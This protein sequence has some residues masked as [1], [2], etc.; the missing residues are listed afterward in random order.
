[1][2]DG[3]LENLRAINIRKHRDEA[4]RAVAEM[5]RGGRNPHEL[6]N[7]DFRNRKPGRYI[8][9][10]LRAAADSLESEG[11]KKVASQARDAAAVA[12]PHARQ[13]GQW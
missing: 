13:T 8:A 10:D 7:D 2:D 5:I 9:T 6:M 1:M 3:E 12:E 4:G 11:K